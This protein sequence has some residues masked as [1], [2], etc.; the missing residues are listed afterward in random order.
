MTQPAP[1]S[2][3]HGAPTAWPVMAMAVIATGFLSGVGGTVLS[4]LLHM[5]QHVAYGYGQPGGLEHGEPSRAN[6]K[7]IVWSDC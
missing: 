6:S 5:I 1:A 3:P 2:A 4:V 7:A